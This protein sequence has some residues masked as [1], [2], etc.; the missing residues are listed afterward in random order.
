MK[1]NNKIPKNLDECTS[2]NPTATLL[3]NLANSIVNYCKIFCWLA[4]TSIIVSTGVEAYR[5]YEAELDDAGAATIFRGVVVLLITIIGAFFVSSI[6][7][8]VL[9]GIAKIV[10]N[11]TISANVALLEASQNP[12]I[13][14]E[15]P[16]STEEKPL[17]Q[18]PVNNLT[19]SSVSN[20]KSTAPFKCGKCGKEGPYEDLC[21]ECGSSIKIFIH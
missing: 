12:N 3:E 14:K 10:E 7:I 17:S 1:K 4:A 20:P 13:P 16:V 9:S 15:A 6:I 2:K 21:P 18:R 5:L 11:T 8:A 19:Q